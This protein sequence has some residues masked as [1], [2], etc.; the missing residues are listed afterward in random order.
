MT[1]DTKPR[2]KQPPYMVYELKTDI[3]RDEDSVAL[4]EPVSGP[5]IGLAKATKAMAALPEGDYVVGAMRK[6]TIKPKPVVQMML[7]QEVDA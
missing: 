5:H 3:S 2:K 4:L 1:E 6:F 7:I